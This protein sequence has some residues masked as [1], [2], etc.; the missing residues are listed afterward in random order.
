VQ[1]A[2]TTP[3]KFG[4]EDCIAIMLPDMFPNDG[5]SPYYC[6]VGHAS[7]QL[8]PVHDQFFVFFDILHPWKPYVIKTTG[9]KIQG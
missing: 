3:K 5:I 8:L 2:L 4:S 7:L 6:L 9:R 1:Q